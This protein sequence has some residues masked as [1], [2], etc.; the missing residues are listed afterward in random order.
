MHLFIEAEYEG[1]TIVMGDDPTLTVANVTSTSD[2]PEAPSEKP[3]LKADDS[4]TTTT[5][6]TTEAAKDKE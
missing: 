5:S 6:T 4:K 2:K 1:A 3:D